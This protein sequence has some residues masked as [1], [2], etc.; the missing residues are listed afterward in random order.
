VYFIAAI[1]D[2]PFGIIG[3]VSNVLKNAIVG[4]RIEKNDLNSSLPLV[5]FL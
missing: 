3:Q 1:I 5:L 2:A 4:L